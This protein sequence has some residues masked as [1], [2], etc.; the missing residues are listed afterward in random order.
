MDGRINKTAHGTVDAASVD[1]G[2]D[3]DSNGKV[4]IKKEREFLWR[5]D[6]GLLTIGFLGYVF[7]Y[8]DQIN[9]SNAYVSGMQDDLKLY[10]DEL[11]Y[12]TTYFN[13]G[14]MV[15]LF[16]SCI[17]VSYIGPSIWLPACEVL[18]GVFTCCLSTVT[19]AEQVYG[20]R[21]LIGFFEGVTWPGYYTIISQWYLPHELALRMSI[22]NIAQ[23][24]GAMMSGAMQ[25]A[26]ATNLNGSF[27]RAGWRWAFL[28]NGVCTIF[29]ALIAFIVLPGYPERPNPLSKFYLKPRH[30]EVALARG[31]RVGR[32]AQT[33]ITIKSFL[34]TFKIWFYW[35]IVIAWPIGGNTVPTN[36]FNLWLKSLKNADGT[37]KYSVGMLNYLPI[38]GQAIQLVAEVLFSSLSDRFGRFPF[39]LLHS[40]VNIA[41]L[42]ILIVRP[43]NQQTHMAGYYLNYVGGVSLMLLCS[44]ASTHLQDEPEARTI[45]FASGT[46]IAYALN[47]FVPIAAFPASEA[48]HW[49]IGAKLYLGFAVLALFI[50]IGIHIGF[51]R[52]AKKKAT[53]QQVQ[54]E[55]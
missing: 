9:I 24:V 50:F 45:L 23:P 52:D 6:L 7:K 10:G 14:Y 54:A 39:L 4:D 29:I 43:A 20:L 3:S 51:R 31:R 32:K 47:A 26:L 27:G 44:W 19:S 53:Q 16:P 48:P 25:G 13:I 15:M 35:A 18:W 1:D 42:V 17:L 8:L 55:F 30:I 11:N 5:L 34:R 2:V 33:G 37:A 41:S 36:Y 40:A 46:I 21:F 12:F 49:R 38:V 28:I 22:Y